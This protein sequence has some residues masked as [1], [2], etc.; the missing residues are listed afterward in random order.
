M[1]LPPQPPLGSD[2]HST[3]THTRPPLHRDTGVQAIESLMAR[4]GTF[5]YILL[6]TTGLA[7]PGNI[8]PLFWLDDG[9][10]ASIYLDGVVT[11]VDG[12][13]IVRTLDDRETNDA[14]A[15]AH[16]D[17][18]GDENSG[19]ERGKGNGDEE[20]KV[21]E[22][23]VVEKHR[24][25][26]HYTT[27]HLQISHADV[28]I[29]NKSDLLPTSAEQEAVVQR[30]KGINGLARVIVTDHGRVPALEGSVLDLHAY[31]GVEEV[32]F[33]GKGHS[34]LDGVSYFLVLGDW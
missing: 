19:E 21:N 18:S 25:S 8:A 22:K 5:D 6:E 3:T 14:V 17:H 24:I 16:G 2:T 29:V 33:G 1:A 11:L 23:G 15:N 20:G 9:L 13:N 31:E 10:G 30:V 27:A 26:P 4:R 12:K 7:D 28:I 32:D 34:H